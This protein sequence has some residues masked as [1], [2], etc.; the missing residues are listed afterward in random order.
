MHRLWGPVAM[1]DTVA[2]S[3][4]GLRASGD[5]QIA[6]FR[7]RMTSRN[8]LWGPSFYLDLI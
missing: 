7:T 1:S 5:I 8:M 3:E 2:G 6:R 4:S